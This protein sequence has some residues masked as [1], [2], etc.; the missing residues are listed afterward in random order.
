MNEKGFGTSV[1]YLGG[2]SVF[3]F[4]VVNEAVAF[5][6]FAFPVYPWP[7]VINGKMLCIFSD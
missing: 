1:L 7:P 6:D 4:S 2:T 5:W 3:E